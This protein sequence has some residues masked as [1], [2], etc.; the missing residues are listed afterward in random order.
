MCN[1][2]NLILMLLKFT[3]FLV[4]NSRLPKMIDTKELRQELLLIEIKGL[5][6]K[7]VII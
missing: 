3:A 2:F 4:L 6:Q 1:V 5:V 7:D